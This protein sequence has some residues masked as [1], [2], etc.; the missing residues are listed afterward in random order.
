MNDQQTTIAEIKK[1][2][3]EYRQARGWKDEDPKDIAIGMEF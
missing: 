2:V 3:N 1:R